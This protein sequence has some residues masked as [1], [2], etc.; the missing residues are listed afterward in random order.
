M[1][2]NKHQIKRLRAFGNRHR[3]AI[4]LVSLVCI[5]YLLTQPFWHEEPGLLQ[6]LYF[7]VGLAMAVIFGLMQYFDRFVYPRVV[8]EG[9]DKES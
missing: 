3:N 6:W 4:A 1:K 2:L 5:C 8:A 9:K 7:I